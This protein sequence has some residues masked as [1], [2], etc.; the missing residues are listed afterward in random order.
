MV[1]STETDVGILS[2]SLAKGLK[3]CGGGA[4]SGQTAA[5]RSW[6]P[7]HALSEAITNN[8]QSS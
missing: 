5:D 4:M 1:S 2:S 6:R 8:V 3:S 7:S